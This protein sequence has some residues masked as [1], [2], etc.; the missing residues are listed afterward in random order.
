M[1]RSEEWLKELF[2]QIVVFVIL[3]WLLIKCMVATFLHIRSGISL[4]IPWLQVLVSHLPR[5]A[6]ISAVIGT[7]EKTAKPFPKQTI[8]TDFIMFTNNPK[9]INSGNWT[10]DHTPYHITQSSSL[11]TGQ[12]I[13]SFSKNRHTFN[14]AKY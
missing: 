6:I 9:L 12:F 11:D 7:Y 13:N 5:V 3:L 2:I 1:E 10:I 14:I 4:P 8:P